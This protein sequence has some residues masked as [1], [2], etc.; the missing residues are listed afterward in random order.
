VK[1]LRQLALRGRDTTGWSLPVLTA[2]ALVLVAVLLAVIVF[3]PPM[4]ID[5]RGLTRTDWLKAVQDL[6][7][8]ILQALGGLALLSTLY[9]SARTLR[10]NRRGQLTERFGRAI[11]QLG[12]GTLAIRLGGIYALEQIAVDSRELHW[13]VMEVLTAFL[14][15]HAPVDTTTATGTVEKR[16]P[17]DHQAIAT[18]I[19]RR[20]REHD[21]HRLELAELDLPGV[22]WR[23]AYL[24][25]ANLW[26]TNLKGAYLRFAHLENARLDAANLGDARLERAHLDGARLV[27]ANLSSAWLGN[28]DLSTVQGLTWE[29]LRLV[30]DL[31]GA[32]LPSDIEQ[33]SEQLVDDVP[34]PPPTAQ[35]R[36]SSS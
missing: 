32:A 8:T 2:G 33:G 27:G 6:R 15:E 21:L 10:L 16:L 17:V 23:G 35:D 14:R 30:C 36:P 9:F 18:V 29:Q 11:E 5:S 1:R 34:T 13:P 7:A 28:T 3:L 25:R 4:A 26:R 19:G 20:R 22:Q 12:S 24:Q 31:D